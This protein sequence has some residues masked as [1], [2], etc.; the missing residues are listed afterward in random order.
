VPPPPTS[1]TYINKKK[2]EILFNSNFDS[3][4][5]IPEIKMH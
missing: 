5:Q 1:R 3:Q 2:K 4:L